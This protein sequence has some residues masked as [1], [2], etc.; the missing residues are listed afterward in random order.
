[1]ISRDWSIRS[2]SIAFAISLAL[3][4]CGNG[5]SKHTATATATTDAPTTAL[6]V[7]VSTSS[8]QPSTAIPTVGVP[9]EVTETDTDPADANVPDAPRG[10]FLL[11]VGRPIAI[12]AYPTGDGTKQ[13]E[14]GIPLT[15][16]PE[17]GTPIV[18]V[19]DMG[20]STADPAVENGLI[21]TGLSSTNE[22]DQELKV[23]S[24]A[25]GKVP[26][27]GD[28]ATNAGAVDDGMI[29]LTLYEGQATKFTGCATFVYSA[30]YIPTQFHLNGTHWSSEVNWPIDLGSVG[31]VAQP[32]AKTLATYQGSGSHL[33]SNAII[34]KYVK[35]CWQMTGDGNNII[36]SEGT[37]GG[38]G[39][40]VLTNTIGPI[41]DCAASVLLG[42]YIQVLASGGW[43]I[44]VTGF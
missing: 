9:Y 28:S 37:S 8:T 35:V 4:G 32:Q 14:V 33:V 40:K 20:L 29:N 16:E 27:L 39:L 12:V 18:S 21:S 30:A 34:G 44:T 15:F 10:T 11:T 41:S 3:T 31:K 5:G 38:D 19:S 7:I 23:D 22:S 17:T 6:P 25:C 13:Y 43:S 26:Q 1:M 24:A 36:E 2:A 42:R